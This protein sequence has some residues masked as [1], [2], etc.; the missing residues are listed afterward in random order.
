MSH[1]VL[2]DAREVTARAE[3][4]ARKWLRLYAARHHSGDTR[5]AMQALKDRL[6]AG[7]TFEQRGERMMAMDF[8]AWNDFLAKMKALAASDAVAPPTPAPVSQVFHDDDAFSDAPAA[9]QGS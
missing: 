5:A 6:P 1:A 4:C 8:G 9:L 7:T 2:A 3:E